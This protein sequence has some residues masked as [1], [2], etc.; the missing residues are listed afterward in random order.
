MLRRRLAV[1]R[2]VGPGRF[3]RATDVVTR[4]ACVQSQEY[5]HGFWSLGM[6]TDGLSFDDVR[7]EFDAGSFVRTHILRPTWHFVAAADLRWILALTS[8]RVHQRSRSSY[9]QLGL[10]E[11]DLRRGAEVI[12][13][14]LEGGRHL[15]RRELGEVLE[16]DGI[17]IAGQRLAYLVMA[18][19]LDGLVC[20]GRMRGAQHTY[21]LGAERLPATPPRTPEDALAELAWRYFAGRGPST[22]A[23]LARWSSLTVSDVRRGLDLAGDRLQRLVVDGLE[24]W[25]DPAAGDPAPDVSAALLLPLYDE[26][27]LSYPGLSFPVAAGH[28][29][30]PGEDQFV[31][32]VVV[33]AVNV[34]T[35][36]RTVKGKRVEVGTRLAPGL[37]PEQRAAV[38]EAVDRLA[39]FLG[40]ELVIA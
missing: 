35:W 6:R 28:P 3:S 30:V 38:A 36:R 14:A 32:S 37:A 16:R 34:G 26:A 4:L 40:K 15:I 19:E 33:D 20:S 12:A 9:E 10:T 7:S 2:L 21:A 24:L 39:A 1:Q 17:S 8:P 18:A 11:P 27:T 13:G 25:F 31:G 5:A 22:A 23:D 29:H